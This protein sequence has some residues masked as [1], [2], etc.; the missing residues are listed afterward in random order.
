MEFVISKHC[1]EQ[2]KLRG[3]TE[4]EVFSILKKPDHIIKQNEETTVYQSLTF[5][6]SLLIR[7]F[8]NTSK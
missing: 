1:L 6:G 8:V 7:I 3:I 2:I 5:D 4:E